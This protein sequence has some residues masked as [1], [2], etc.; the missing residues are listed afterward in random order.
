MHRAAVNDDEQVTEQTTPTFIEYLEQHP[1]LP[2]GTVLR[3]VAG[4]REFQLIVRDNKP[5]ERPEPPKVHPMIRCPDCNDDGDL[6]EPECPR[7]NTCGQ[8]GPPY[9][10][11]PFHPWPAAELMGDTPWVVEHG[12]EIHGIWLAEH[13]AE[14]HGIEN[15][16]VRIV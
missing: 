8:I 11:P 6:H 13:A 3:I 7:V 16:Q 12:G 4:N 1:E 9:L 2:P 5:A 15:F 14:I 10:P